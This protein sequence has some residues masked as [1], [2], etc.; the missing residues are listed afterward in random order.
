MGPVPA[1]ALG[2]LNGYG[3]VGHGQPP[4]DADPHHGGTGATGP[5]RCAPVA[6]GAGGGEPALDR[7]EFGR[8]THRLG[9]APGGCGDPVTDYRP[10]GVSPAVDRSVLYQPGSPGVSDACG[11]PPRGAVRDTRNAPP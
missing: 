1:P 3:P 4:G 9:R 2:S 10:A 11:E 8:G 6:A 7:P 5:A